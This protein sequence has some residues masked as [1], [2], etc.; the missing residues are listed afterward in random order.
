MATVQRTLTRM[1]AADAGE[2]DAL[3][4]EWSALSDMARKLETGRIDI[5]LFGEVSSGKSALRVNRRHDLPMSIFVPSA[6]N[7]APSRASWCGTL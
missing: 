7:A 3:V 2:R 1:N 4:Q 6:A 5:A